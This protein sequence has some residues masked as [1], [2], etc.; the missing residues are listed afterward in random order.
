[1]KKFAITLATLAMA[2]LFCVPAQAESILLN[3]QKHYY[4]VQLRSDKRAIVYA[5]IIFENPSADKD[6]SSYEFTLPN[7]VSAQNISSQQILARGVE[8]QTCNTYET[9]EQW[10]LRVNKNSYTYSD[11]GYQSGKQCIDWQSANKYDADYDYDKNLSSTTNYYYY[12]YYQT[13]DTKFDYVDLSQK[14]TGS[15][16][17]VSLSEPVKPK[18]Q[19]S[20][21]I[22]FTTNDYVTGGIFGR[23]DYNIRTLLAKQMIDRATVSVNFDD[24]M[25]TRDATQKRTYEPTSGNLTLKDGVSSAS[26]NASYQSRSLDNLV[27]HVGNGGIYVKS[28]DSLLPGDTLRI[29]GV[30]GTNTLILYSD[31]IIITLLVLLLIGIAFRIYMLW[32]KA[33]RK[34]TGDHN[35]RLLFKNS[36]ILKDGGTLGN[37][38]VSRITLTSG[39]SIIGSLVISFIL[40]FAISAGNSYMDSAT[41]ALFAAG[42][43]LVAL[44]GALILPGLYMARYGV[45]NVYRWAL[46]QFIVIVIL[47]LL[48]VALT[49]T[50]RSPIDNY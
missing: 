17:T 21:L 34:N 9:L 23:Y 40:S 29:T 15:N 1:M 18:K 36:G 30:F 25:F 37:V 31:E 20:L 50:G 22:S 26:G 5:R 16:Y 48:S 42:F 6:L 4:T 43:V 32:R 14:N 39:V 7:G 47:L 3:G 38:A 46:L 24:D 2:V 11:T 33:H 10:R 27:D 44:F 13:R 41:S 8:T 28:Q 35:N 49:S 19:G 45:R 12:S